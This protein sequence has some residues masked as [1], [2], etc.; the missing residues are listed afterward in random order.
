MRPRI[1][2]AAKLY[3]KSCDALYKGKLLVKGI[4]SVIKYEWNRGK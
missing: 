4:G 1:A 3:D 2:Q